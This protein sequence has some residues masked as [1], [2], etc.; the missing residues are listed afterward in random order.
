[1][2]KARD[3]KNSREEICK[4]LYAEPVLRVYG[5]LDA[6]TGTTANMGARADTRGG[7]VDARTH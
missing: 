3:P 6:L 5:N 1:V 2:N 7:M 4:K